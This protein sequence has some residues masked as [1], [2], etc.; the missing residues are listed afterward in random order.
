MKK[1]F[2]I[3]MALLAFTSCKKDYTCTYTLIDTT[4]ESKFTNLD[5][6][7]AKDAK[8]NCESVEGTWAVVKKVK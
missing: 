6:K 8:A 4:V 2:F 1:V 7:Q 5:K 3:G